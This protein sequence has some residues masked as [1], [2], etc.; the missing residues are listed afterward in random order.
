MRPSALVYSDV[1]SS[2][3]VRGKGVVVPE[4]VMDKGSV[5]AIGITP[6]DLF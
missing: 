4:I 3:L 5:N 1:S 6:R 2:T